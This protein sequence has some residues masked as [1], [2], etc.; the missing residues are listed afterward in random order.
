MIISV[1]DTETTG[2]PNYETPSDDDSQPHIV[3]LCSKQVDWTSGDVI[4]SM[5]FIVKPSGWAIPLDVVKIHG[6]DNHKAARFGIDEKLAVGMF[7]EM[8]KRSDM[9][10]AHN[11]NFDK[12]IV[13]IALMRFFGRE[14]AD[15]AKT[16]MSK[17]RTI[18]TM[19]KAIKIV[20]VGRYPSLAKCYKHF[21]GQEIKK[22]HDAEGDVDSCLVVLKHLVDHG[23]VEL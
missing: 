12:R 15:E 10:V 1:F 18:C 14:V 4:Q 5:K 9:V 3:Q 19:N 21:T 16:Y 23:A 2:I 7:L 13:R 6:I 20:G 17:E 22:A 11:A 8:V